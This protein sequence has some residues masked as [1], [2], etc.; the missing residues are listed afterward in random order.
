M[1]ATA[2]EA[3]NPA[4]LSQLIADSGATYMMATATTWAALVAAG[5]RGNRRLTVVSVGETL[6][7]RLAENGFDL[8]RLYAKTADLD[9]VVVTAQVL[10]PAVGQEPATIACAVDPP[11]GIESDRLQ[12]D[13][14]ALQGD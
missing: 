3:A 9:L 11:A 1:L 8:A 6:S 7:D 5:W 4:A 2:A 12:I 14:L 10:Y 13:A